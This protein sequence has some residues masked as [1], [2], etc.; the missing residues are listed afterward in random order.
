MMGGYTRLLPT[1]DRHLWTHSQFNDRLATMLGGHTAENLIFGEVSTGASSDLQNV[2]R[3]S[4]HM[5][6]DYGMSEKLGPRSFGRRGELI[7]LG[8]E[9]T[10]EQ[11][12]YSDKTAESIDEEVH[13]IVQRA[14]NVAREVLTANKEKL[15]KLAEALIANE[16][17]EGEA[18]DAIL[19][20]RNNDTPDKPAS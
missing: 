15:V 18:L 8:R 6:T 10:E 16:T 5:V 19:G 13:N 17:I 14:Q 3:T 2:A 9:V 7:F 11:K 1:E 12:D 20:K 4:R